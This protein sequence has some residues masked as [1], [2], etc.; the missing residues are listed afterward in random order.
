[1]YKVITNYGDF[2]VI[3]DS[4]TLAN[5]KAEELVMQY[6]GNAVIKEVVMI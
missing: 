2:Y 5:C 6:G 4:L 3:A 1:M